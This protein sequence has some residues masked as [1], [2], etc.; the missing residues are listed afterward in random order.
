MDRLRSSDPATRSGQRALARPRIARN[1]GGSVHETDRRVSWNSS[2][3]RPDPA[4]ARRNVLR[5]ASSSGSTA[6]KVVIDDPDP[7]VLL[8]DYLHGIGLTGTKVG[9]GQGGCGACTVML[10]HRDPATG[11]PGPP[12]RQRLPAAALRGRRHDGHDHRRHRQR[13]R[14]ARPGPA[15]HRGAQR[16]AMR[17]LHAGLRHERPRLPAAEAGAHRSRRSRT[18]SAATSAAAR[19]IAP[20]FTACGPW[21]ATTMPPRTGPR[22]A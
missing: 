12:R 1:G 21:P 15:L 5:P 19:A 20:S 4:R 18:S 14:R 17:V 2:L 6:S 9:C 10:S 11:Q 3:M 7:S 22:N 13:P 8:V 16:H